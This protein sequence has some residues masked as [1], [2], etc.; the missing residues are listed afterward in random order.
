MIFEQD[1]IA[2]YK[3]KFKKKRQPFLWYKAAFYPGIQPNA[4]GMSFGR[5]ISE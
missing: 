1:F 4:S 3:L 2:I 5:I